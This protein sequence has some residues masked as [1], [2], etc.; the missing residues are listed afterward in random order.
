M[1]AV[2]AA[3]VVDAMAAAAVVVV[4]ADA[5]AVVATVAG[6]VTHADSFIPSNPKPVII[7]LRALG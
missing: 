3:A 2:L 6:A 7:N 1:A 5:Q 4:V